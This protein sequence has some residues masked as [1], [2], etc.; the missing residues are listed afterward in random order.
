M[1]ATNLHQAAM[2][3]KRFHDAALAYLDDT[4]SIDRIARLLVEGVNLDVRLE[5]L[6]GGADDR[7]S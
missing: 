3:A 5:V 4:A 2:A 1:D 6:K 7:T